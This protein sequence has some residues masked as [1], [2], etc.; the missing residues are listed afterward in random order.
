MPYKQYPEVIIR[1]TKNHHI[2]KPLH[3]SLRFPGAI[4]E[5]RVGW[6]ALFFTAPSNSSTNSTP[7]L[8]DFS[9]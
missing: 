5:N 3:S 2:W 4:K 9:S 1:D 8:G 6:V 7:R